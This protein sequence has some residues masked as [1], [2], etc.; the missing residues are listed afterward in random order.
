MMPISVTCS[1]CGESLQA[2]DG[3]AGRTLKCP[4]CKSPIT[5]PDADVR[6]GSAST[7]GG[8]VFCRECGAPAPDGDQAFCRECGAPTQATGKAPRQD[9]ANWDTKRQSRIADPSSENSLINPSKVIRGLRLSDGEMYVRGYQFATFGQSFLL[10]FR[11]A[12]RGTVNLILTNKRIICYSTSNAFFNRGESWTEIPIET[13]TCINST[14]ARR[15]SLV[16]VAILSILTLASLIFAIHFTATEID[17]HNRRLNEVR[18]QLNSNRQRFSEIGTRLGEIDRR[19]TEIPTRLAEIPT[20]L[21]EIGTRLAVIDTRLIGGQRLL[22]DDERRALSDERRALSDEQSTLSDEQSTRLSEI[23]T[24]LAEIDT[25]LAGGR[26][27]LSDDEQR[28]LSDEQKTLSDERGRLPD[29]QRRLPDEQRRLRDERNNFQGQRVDM[30]NRI[31]STENQIA[32]LEK[33]SYYAFP[34]ISLTGPLFWLLCLLFLLFKTR[35]YFHFRVYSMAIKETIDVIGTGQTGPIAWLK[36]ILLGAV[37]TPYEFW[38]DLSV[39][40]TTRTMLREVGAVVQDIK[41]QGD[42]GAEK[43]RKLP[44]HDLF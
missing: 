15:I 27:T 36:N 40:P 41:T 42:R 19:L 18:Q 32:E 7:G 17:A 33:I 6:S 37:A 22:S 34:F 24:R 26:W 31:R 5:V 14:L 1:S 8:S 16:R 39:T 38:I 12:I 11:L 23:G 29:E 28:A 35:P 25:R 10:M 43:W 2:K 9:D 30:E 21:S 13:A 44:H 4:N 20:R 3:H